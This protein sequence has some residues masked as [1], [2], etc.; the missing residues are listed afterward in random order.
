MSRQLRLLDAIGTLPLGAYSFRQLTKKFT[1]PVFSMNRDFDNVRR[2]IY[3]TPA[4]EV[5][6][7][8]MVNFVC[9][10][11]TGTYGSGTLV[12]WNNQINFGQYNLAR[13]TRGLKVIVYGKVN[14]NNRRVCP[15]ET[16]NASLSTQLPL[17]W[18]RQLV[19]NLVLV[20]GTDTANN[21]AYIAG[22]DASSSTYRD[23]ML[24]VPQNSK[25]LNWGQQMGTMTP[26]TSTANTNTVQVITVIRNPTGSTTKGFIRQNGAVTSTFTA[27]NI[28]T[29]AQANRFSIF[30]NP[31]GG[32]FNTPGFYVPG[33]WGIQEV[34]VFN[35][36]SPISASDLYT[37]E[38][39]QCQ[40]YGVPFRGTAPA[41]TPDA[42]GDIYNLPAQNTIGVVTNGT[43]TTLLTD[44]TGA[45]LTYV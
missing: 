20:R 13:V 44:N 30:G 11:A 45:F 15:K 25:Q 14:T 43:S 39:D 12:G 32:G 40:Y 5:D 26:N 37:I 10:A 18:S 8:D 21:S 28:A 22:V 23:C 36:T 2:D 35:P 31:D 19:I 9:N 4:G 27:E 7:Q 6:Q 42:S 33:G 1:G 16:G 38:S 24:S 3:F 34:M 41:L 17:N 29:D